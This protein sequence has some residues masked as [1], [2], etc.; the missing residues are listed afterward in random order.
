MSSKLKVLVL[1]ATGNQ[2]GAVARALRAKGHSVRAL[3][4]N[5]NGASAASLK[6]LGCELVVGTMAN[7]K[8]LDRAC[9]GVDTVF[10]ISTFFE[11]GLENEVVQGKNAIDAAVAARVKHFVFNSVGCADRNTGIPHFESKLQIENHLKKSGL[12]YTIVGPVFFMENLLSPWFLPSLRSGVLAMALPA[13]RDLAMVSVEDIGHFCATVIENASAFTNR[14][15]DIAG[16][17]L[18]GKRACEIL[19]KVAGRPVRYQEI[20]L[21]EIAK[22]NPDFAKM[23]E[24][25]D[26]VGYRIDLGSLRKQSPGMQWRSFENWARQQ[27][28]NVLGGASALKKAA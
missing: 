25:F 12:P 16:D 10:A 20:P 4:R 27:N 26:K 2:G 6:L 8:D 19:S 24:W 14:R 13:G 7:R 17:S 11:E 22:Q 3:T 28:W 21:I 9:A 23:Y 5:P 1:G 15:I 18:S